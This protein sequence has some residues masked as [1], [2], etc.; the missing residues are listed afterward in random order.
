MRQAPE[1][2]YLKIKAAWRTLLRMAGGAKHVIEQ[3][4]T[5]G[6]ESRMSEAGAPNCMDRFPMLDQVYDL[7][8]ECG[9]PVMTKALAD[10]H[11]FDLVQRDAAKP[12]GIHAHFATIIGETRDVELTMAKAI[13]DGSLD[14]AER[15][16]IIRECCEAISALQAMLAELRAKPLRVVG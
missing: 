6:S 10:L 8:L 5:R 16:A 3:G 14:D 12:I 7:E 4:I 11:G 9:E 15:A 13:A 2:D 1:I